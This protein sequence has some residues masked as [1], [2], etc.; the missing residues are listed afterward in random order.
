MVFPQR[1]LALLLLVCLLSSC[2]PGDT[3]QPSPQPSATP[4]PTIQPV[5]KTW[6]IGL[7]EAPI[8]LYPYSGQSAAAPILALLYPPPVLPVSGGALQGVEPALPYTSTGVLTRLP[9]I[10][11][12]GVITQTTT[13]FLDATGAVT[14]TP[15]EITTEVIQL[16]VTYHWNPSLRWS[17]GQPVTAEDSVFAYNVAR[18]STPTPETVRRLELTARYEAVDTHTTRAYLPPGLSAPDY[19][20]TAWLPLPRHTLGDIP[21]TK[22]RE[23]LAWAPLGYGPYILARSQPGELILS[24]RPDASTAYPDQVS[25]HFFA[26][27]ASLRTEVLAGRVDVAISHLFEPDQL[28]FLSQ[29]QQTKALQVLSVPGP[30]WEH[31][32]INIDI[33]PFDDPRVRQALALGMNRTGLVKDLFDNHAQVMDSWIGP[34]SWAYPTEGLSIYPYDPEQAKRLLDE[35][36]LIDTDGDGIRE[37]ESGQPFS[38]TLLTSSGTPLREEIARRFQAD[39]Q[40]LGLRVTVKLLPTEAL[41]SQEGPLFRRQFT[42]ALF[43]WLRAADPDGAVLW[44]CLAVP[45]SLNAWSGNNFAGWCDLAADQALREATTTLD[46]ALRRAAY[47]HHQRRFTVALPVIPL[48]AR[49][50]VILALPDVRGLR[51]DAFAPLVWNIHQWRRGES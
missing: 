11:N 35:A 38:A 19:L 9:T 50:I 36:G 41:Y 1:P 33:R 6:R 4:A 39:M 47:N 24:R 26:D 17:D 22:V 43:G 32:D 42:L 45:G 49:P 3:A 29:D 12:G 34:D 10:A 8:D 16:V 5:L 13:V 44:G 37:L 25:F 48:F 30:V 14:T 46:G 31:L 2:R 51:P 23:R 18:A 21:A 27:L 28:P 20:L 15:T 7:S 40:A